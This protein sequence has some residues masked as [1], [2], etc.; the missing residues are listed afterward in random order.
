MSVPA[1]LSEAQWGSAGAHLRV[2]RALW[3]AW[4][5]D[6]EQSAADMDHSFRIIM[7]ATDVREYEF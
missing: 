2:S 5:G 7:T 1:L 3:E 4:L 6:P